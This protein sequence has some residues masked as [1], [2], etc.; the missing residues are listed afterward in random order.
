MA[1]IALCTYLG[2]PL[3]SKCRRATAKPSDHQY[4]VTNPS[5]A[6]N[7]KFECDMYLGDG[8]DMLLVQLKS[9]MKKSTKRGKK[10]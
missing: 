8:A 1:D 9:L 3:R 7:G 4:Y 6:I 2:C 5:R 10:N